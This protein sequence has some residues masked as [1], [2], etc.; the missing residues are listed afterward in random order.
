MSFRVSHTP[1]T[2]N[3]SF[4]PAQA[5]QCKGAGC[6]NIGHPQHIKVKVFNCILYIIWMW[7]ALSAGLQPQPWQRNICRSALPPIAIVQNSPPC[8]GMCNSA[9]VHQYAHPQHIKVF[10]YLLYIYNMNVGCSLWV[11]G[12]LGVSSLNHDTTTLFRV[13]HSPKIVQHFI[14][15]CT[16]ITV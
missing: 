8:H 13:S 15:T 14:P 2:S 1:K 3:I 16:G 7:D 12:S 5:L 11:F 4:P 6:T 9:R 10:N